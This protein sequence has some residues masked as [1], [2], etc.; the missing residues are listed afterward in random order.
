[1]TKMRTVLFAEFRSF[2]QQ[3]GFVEKSHP[4]ARVFEHPEEGL[5]AF[6]L[7]R[8]DEP[9]APRDLLNTRR[10]LNLR[11]ILETDEFD[12]QLLRANTPA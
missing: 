6:R 12:A 8:E 2:L 4:T 5:L 11:G 1:M 3:F 9:L 10:F 7:Y